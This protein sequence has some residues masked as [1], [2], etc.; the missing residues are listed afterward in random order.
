VIGKNLRA[1]ATPIEGRLVVESNGGHAAVTV[2]VE[3]P[4]AP[5]P[6]GV[7][8]GATTP[9]ELAKKAKA[10]AKEAARLVDAGAAREWY[11]TNGWTYPIRG[12]A[13]RGLAGVQQFFEALGLVKPPSIVI[14]E[15]RLPLLGK[16][17]ESLQYLLKV[18]AVQ[19]KY[20]YVQAR[21]TV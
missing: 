4:T 21:S 17:G 8:A 3:V 7:L 12:A 6:R 1:R 19:K 11:E 5:F 20:V 15:R 9:R 13:A 2:R 10:A 18:Q 16:P 14:G